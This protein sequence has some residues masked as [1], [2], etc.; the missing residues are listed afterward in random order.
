MAVSQTSMASLS[1]L[2]TMVRRHKAQPHSLLPREQ[3][4]F[5]LLA[6]EWQGHI[7]EKHVQRT[8]AVRHEDINMCSCE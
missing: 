2:A 5:H 8:D 3:E 7:A 6:G 4:E 1:P